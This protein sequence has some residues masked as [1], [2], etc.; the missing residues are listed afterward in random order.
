MTSAI[1]TRR[2][3]A[4]PPLSSAGWVR[5]WPL[6]PLL[7]LIVAFFLYPVLQILWLSLINR[8]GELSA[9]NYL[10][11]TTTPVYLRTLGITLQISAWTTAFSLLAGYPVAYLLATARP[12]TRDVLTILVLMPFV[13]IILISLSNGAYLSPLW[14]TNTGHFLLGLGI[15]MITIG[16]L[17]L[18]KMVDIKA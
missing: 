15:V 12:R 6:Y 9:E 2:G 5:A 17:I 16:S 13:V 11:A 3:R 8:A 1:E 4:G 14:H 18:R 10:R 7:L